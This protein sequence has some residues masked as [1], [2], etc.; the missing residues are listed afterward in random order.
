[1]IKNKDWQELPPLHELKTHF[2][3]DHTSP[4]G[5]RWLKPVRPGRVKPGDVAGRK[6]VD[7]SWGVRF[8]IKRYRVHRIIFYLIYEVLF[9]SFQ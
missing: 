9:C 1:M 7:G 2:K 6:D 3:V 5:L 8:K 4:S